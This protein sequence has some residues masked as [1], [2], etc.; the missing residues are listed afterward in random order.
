M[1]HMVNPKWGGAQQIEMGSGAIWHDMP[2]NINE[3]GKGW[4]LFDNFSHLPKHASTSGGAVTAALGDYHCYLDQGGY[5][6][7]PTVAVAD[8]GIECGADG[9]N[10]IVTLIHGGS[11]KALL[12]S[13]APAMWFEGEFSTSLITSASQGIFFGLVERTL[14]ATDVLLSDSDAVADLNLIGFKKTEAAAT[15]T[16]TY[17]A[18]GQTAQVPIASAATLAAATPVRVGFKLLP[19]S[20]TSSSKRIY[21]YV[22][23]ADVGT[24]ITKTNMDA[25]TFPSDINLGFGCSA[26]NC[27]ATNPGVATFKWWR[28]A[29]AAFV[30]N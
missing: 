16:F 5:I 2:N 21:V 3:P 27:T 8:P 25:A 15:L 9:D 7:S 19:A 6:R 4:M 29:Q 26:N 17:K 10:E 14:A 30:S 12:S 24:Y 13:S 11:A 22:N 20:R 18:D 23:G 28:L 1:A